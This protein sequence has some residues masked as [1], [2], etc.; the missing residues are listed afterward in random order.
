M[1]ILGV[2]ASSKSKTTS[3]NFTALAT[4]VVSSPQF[5]VSF[6][7][8]DQN[9]THL[10]L[11]FQ[12]STGAENSGRIYFNDDETHSNYNY[13]WLQ[14]NGVAT[15]VF[16]ETLYSYIYYDNT[17]DSN[18][19]CV[20]IIDIN[21][22]KN[23]NKWKTVSSTNGWSNNNPQAV[24]NLQTTLWKNTNAITKITIKPDSAQNYKVGSTV[25]LYG[26]KTA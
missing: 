2:V 17:T 10:Q 3:G 22:Y 12:L 4:A 25:A 23:T 26:I 5:G 9:F 19:F 14:G 7:N 6:T 11:R 8:I 20:G 15:Y 13:S 24:Q 16:R 21:D 18:L 1:P